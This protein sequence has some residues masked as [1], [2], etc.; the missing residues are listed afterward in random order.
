MVG[1]VG[2]SPIA[3]TN[4]PLSSSV[5]AAGHPPHR[6]LPARSH[7]GQGAAA[8]AERSFAARLLASTARSLSRICIAALSALCCVAAFAQTHVDLQAHR[9]GRGLLPENSLAAFESAIRMGVSA[10]ELD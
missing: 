1:V 5:D 9:G 10:I 6:R 3:P 4:I 7:L 2:S 8:H